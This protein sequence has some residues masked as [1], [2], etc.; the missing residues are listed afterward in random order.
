MT[1]TSNLKIGDTVTVTQTGIVTA[2]DRGADPDAKVVFRPITNSRQERTVNFA[3]ADEITSIKPK[4][5][6]LNIKPGDVVEHILSTTKYV[7][8]SP[9][10]FLKVGGNVHPHS[11]LTVAGTLGFTDDRFRI[12]EL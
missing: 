2:L 1:D 4:V 5:E 7:A 8:L 10:R 9:D 11:A 12:V 3:N 6:K